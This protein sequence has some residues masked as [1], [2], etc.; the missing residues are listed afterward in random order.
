[1]NKTSLMIMG[2]AL[3]FSI[4]VALVVSMKLSPKSQ[5]APTAGTEVLVAG[6]NFAAGDALTADDLHWQSFPDSAVYAGMIKKADQADISKLEIIGKPLR[7]DV[8]SGEPVTTQIIVDEKGNG[9]YLAAS[10][11]PGMRAVGITVRP[12]TMAGGFI[13]PG[14]SVDIILNFQVN[15]KGDA[16]NYSEDTVQRFASETILSNVHVLAVDQTAK[17][18]SHEA[19]AAPRTVTLEVTKQGAQTLAMAGAM[20]QMSLALR[21]LGEKDSDA[22]DATPLTTD[23]S[24]SKVIQKIYQT[25]AAGGSKSADTNVRVYSGNEITNV[26]VRPDAPSEAGD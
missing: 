16:A 9:N 10:L 23:V 5:E 21:R 19:K 2:G 8:T 13:S 3:V 26:P 11:H 1:M 18:D 24:V 14:D 22:D 20:G 25:E 12:E 4:I 7:R 6:K 15:L 17:D